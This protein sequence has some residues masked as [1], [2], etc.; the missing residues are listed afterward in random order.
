MP[1]L[2]KRR[3][4]S[5][6]IACYPHSSSLAQHPVLE[7]MQGQLQ[8]GEAIRFP[9]RHLH[10]RSTG[11]GLRVAHSVAGAVGPLAHQTPLSQDA[12][13]ERSWRRTTCSPCKARQTPPFGLATGHF[14]RPNRASLFLARRLAAMLTR[15]SPARHPLVQ[16]LQAAQ[17]LLH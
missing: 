15:S 13:V 9:R 3:A 11:A 4:A 1:P 12:R 5:K 6:G 8:D 10:H 7:E 16:D 2:H 14:R 17:L